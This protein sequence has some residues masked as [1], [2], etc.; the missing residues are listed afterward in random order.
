M[1]RTEFTSATPTLDWPMETL[2]AR[3]RAARAEQAGSLFRALFARNASRSLETA[4]PVPHA[5]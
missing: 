2:L 4:H 1:N 5:A 3:G